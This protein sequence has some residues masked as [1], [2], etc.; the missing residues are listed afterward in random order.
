M[1][2]KRSYVKLSN[3][4]DTLKSMFA[5]TLLKHRAER[6]V[7]KSET[8]SQVKTAKKTGRKQGFTW[9]VIGTLSVEALTAL[10]FITR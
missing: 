6:V 2:C 8:K 1:D 3:E 10:Y 5:D 9:G 7:W 4:R